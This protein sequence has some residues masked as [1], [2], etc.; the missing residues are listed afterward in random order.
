[1]AAGGPEPEGI[2]VHGLVGARHQ[3]G[4]LLH[5]LST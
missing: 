1:M 5:V 3:D 4:A 2:T